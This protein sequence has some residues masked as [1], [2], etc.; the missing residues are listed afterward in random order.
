MKLLTAFRLAS[1]G[2]SVQRTR[3]N[4]TA[5]NLANAH[6]TRTLEGGPYRAKNL[7]VQ[8]A[9]LTPE[10]ADKLGELAD[11]LET[12]KVIALV[13]DQSPFKEVYDPAHPDADERGIVRYPNVDV[14]TEMVDLLAASR[15]YEANLSVVTVTKNLALKTLEILK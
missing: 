11:K 6:V 13:D 3:L 9:P 15:A 8:A 7:I 2:L 14:L 12:P 5:M 10:L 1:T 4:V